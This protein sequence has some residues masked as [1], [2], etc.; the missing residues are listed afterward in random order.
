M[1]RKSLRRVLCIAALSIFFLGSTAALEASHY[2]AGVRFFMHKNYEKAQENLLKAVENDPNGNAYYFLGEIERIKGDYAKATGYYQ[3]AVQGRIGQ[4]FLR[5]AYWNLVIMTEKQGNYTEL[6]KSLKIFWEKTGSYGAKS[7]VEEIINKSIWSNNPEAIEAYNQG[8][9]KKKSAHDEALNDFNNA[10]AKD[11]NFM[12]PKF[13][14]GI[15]QYRNG[16]LNSA[17]GS[18]SA[19]VGRVPFYGDVHL[20]MGEIYFNSHSYSSAVHHFSRALDYCFLGKEA[21]YSVYM[22]RATSHY[23]LSDYGSAKEDLSRARRIGGGEMEPLL[24]LS[25]I[26]IKQ[27]NYNEAL[28]FLNEANTRQPGNSGIIFQIGSIYYKL[29]DSKYIGYF[30]RLFDIEHAGGGNVPDKYSRAM[31]ILV[32][33]HYNAGKYS[34]AGRILNAL[35]SVDGSEMNA[36]AARTYYNTRDYEKA[37]VYL[38]KLYDNQ[39][40]SLYLAS[41]YARTNRIDK[42]REIVLKYYHDESFRKAAGEKD[43]LRSIVDGVTRKKAEELRIARERELREAKERELRAKR[44]RE[45]REAKERE[46]RRAE[47]MKAAGG[48][49]DS[50]AGEQVPGEQQYHQ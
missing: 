37:I 41:S 23:R 25:A 24:L 20:L 11:P 45:I 22:K 32:K 27:G 7:K 26:N 43:S 34:R 13:E 16:N 28:D 4:K 2:G 50:R 18:F 38:K 17:L 5:L 21:L 12:A 35:S 6:V 29:N 30:D 15:M 19:I 49:G 39:E 31:S 46:M 36:I 10:L 40:N 47:E 1:I 14:I 48:K 8:I 33:D 44:D 3:K 42:A 9:S